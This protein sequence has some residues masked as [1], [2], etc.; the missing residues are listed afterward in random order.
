MGRPFFVFSIFTC[1]LILDD[2]NCVGQGMLMFNC[3]WLMV[4][5]HMAHFEYLK[6]LFLKNP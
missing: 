2:L 5:C 1:G 3:N 6:Q 4:S